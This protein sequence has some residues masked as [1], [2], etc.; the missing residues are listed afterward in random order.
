MSELRTLRGHR[1]DIAHFDVLPID[2]TESPEC[3]LMSGECP[4]F[5]EGSGDPMSGNVRGMSG[6][7]KSQGTD[8]DTP[9][10]RGVRCPLGWSPDFSDW[11]YIGRARM[12]FE[13]GPYLGL[14]VQV[15]TTR[16]CADSAFAQPEP[17]RDVSTQVDTTD[18]VSL[19]PNPPPRRSL[20]CCGLERGRR[21]I[22]SALTP[23]QSRRPSAL[24]FGV[25][26]TAGAPFSR[27]LPDV[28]VSRLRTPLGKPGRRTPFPQL[29]PQN[30]A[31]VTRA[32]RVAEPHSSP[33]KE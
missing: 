10:Y 24:T 20:G 29:K 7:A 25:A 6:P 9:P 4:R 23:A 18:T 21:A 15:P 2:H 28:G 33:A 31:G 17:R 1:A 32:G 11:E 14:P 22:R 16:R 13:R 26:V 12:Y 3:P 30:L 27:Q 8:A 5:S 19:G